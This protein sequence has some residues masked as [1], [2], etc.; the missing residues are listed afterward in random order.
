MSYSQNETS[1]NSATKRSYSTRGRAKKPQINMNMEMEKRTKM[2]MNDGGKES[3]EYGMSVKNPE[4]DPDISER[5]ICT[6]ESSS[7]S[8][9][10]SG[11]KR[12]PSG[13]DRDECSKWSTFAS[14]SFHCKYN[15][16]DNGSA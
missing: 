15:E 13:F 1:L 3:W 11:S 7:A 10:C 16:P 6:I 5:P 4:K 9:C 2:W 8:A 12:R 14:S